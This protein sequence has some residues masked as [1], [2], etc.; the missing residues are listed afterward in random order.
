MRIVS[1]APET[2]LG[3]PEIQLGLFPGGGGTQRL[4]RLI[5]I[6]NALDLILTGKKVRGR[7]A[8]KLGLADELVPAPLL[9]D[10]ARL[11][12]RQAVQGELKPSATGLARLRDLAAGMT[13]P[14]HLQQLALEENPVGQR[15]LFKK[16]R[17]AA[18][19]RTRGNYPAAEKAI[20]VVR[21]GI[22]EGA[23]RATPPRPIASGR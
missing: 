20:E 5:G 3:L 23:R 21:I 11:R 9:L 6:A 22:Q 15:I 19:A 12:A 18:I 10:V 17:D 14:S 13:D 8:V 7:K 1:D 16:A 2:A 4:P